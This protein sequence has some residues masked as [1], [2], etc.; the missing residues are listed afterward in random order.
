MTNHVH[1]VAVPDA[2]DSLAHVM[3]RLN[4]E[5]AQA[6]NRIQE[7]SGHLWQNRFYSCPL[8]ERHFVNALRYTDLNPVRAGLVARALDWPWS[9]AAVHASE[10][11]RDECLDRDWVD[12]AGGWDYC[13][14]K[15]ELE[16][17][18]TD[19]VADG[20]LRR[21]TYTGEPLGSLEFV[22]EL[23]RR[24]GR[25][26]RV[27]KNGRPKKQLEGSGDAAAQDLLFA[28]S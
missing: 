15:N 1:L 10:I 4:S 24:A 20:L 6:L 13:D 12:L 8:D 2:A 25:R 19:G 26:L 21:A 7:R 3:A 18:A 11:L 14:W 28:G 9:S 23:E 22:A 17:S 5:Y 16:A 27:L